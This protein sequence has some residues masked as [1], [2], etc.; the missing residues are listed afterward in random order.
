MQF[1][2]SGLF[3]VPQT[4]NKDEQT[5]HSQKVNQ[6]TYIAPWWFASMG[7]SSHAIGGRFEFSL[8]GFFCQ[9]WIFFR[10]FNPQTQTRDISSA[11]IS[12]LDQYR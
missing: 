5:E 10:W 7:L 8:V 1:V 9:I 4:A 11:N 12:T 3:S 6:G 2:T